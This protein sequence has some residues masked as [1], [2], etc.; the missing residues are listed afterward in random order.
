MPPIVIRK[1]TQ[2]EVRFDCCPTGVSVEFK[3]NFNLPVSHQEY[4]QGLFQSNGLT[5]RPGPSIEH[6]PFFRLCVLRESGQLTVE[7]VLDI[8]W[9]DAEI[10]VSKLAR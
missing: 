2:G 3:E 9:N 5:C 10:D 1:V 8:L 6:T 4:L 7:E